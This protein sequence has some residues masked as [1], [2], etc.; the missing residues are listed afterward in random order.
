VS[1]RQGIE[2]VGRVGEKTRKGA[3]VASTGRELLG[4]HYGQDHLTYEEIEELNLKAV[5]E[6]GRTLAPR[7]SGARS[8][9]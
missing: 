1:L 4:K 7:I 6:D 5:T 8:S 9:A 3:R 2:D